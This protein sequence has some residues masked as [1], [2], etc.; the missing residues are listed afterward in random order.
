[1][2][3]RQNQGYLI[4]I[5][6]LVILSLMLALTAF[7]GITKALE[8]SDLNAQAEAKLKQKTVLAKAYEIHVQELKAMIGNM[9]ESVTEI[10]TN[11]DAMNTELGTLAVT[12]ELGRQAV[13]EVIKSATAAETEFKKDMAL[14]IPSAA[15]EANPQATYRGVFESLVVAL[16][17]KNDDNITLQNEIT[18]IK[19]EA[20]QQI[21]AMKAT[22]DETLAN[23][24]ATRT[25][26][27]TEKEGRAADVAR[28]QS[29]MDQVV[30]SNNQKNIEFDKKAVEFVEVRGKLDSDVT[31]LTKN[32]G[33]LKSQL[34]SFRAENFDVADGRIERVADN[35]GRVYINLGADDGLRNNR[36]FAVYSQGITSFDKNGSK[37]KIEVTRILGPHSAEAKVTFEDV[38]NPILAGDSILSAVWDKGHRVEIALG[39]FFDLDFDTFDDRDKLIQD[40]ESNGGKVVAWHDS[41]GR[42]HGEITP[43]TRYFVQGNS[44]P[45]GPDFNPN[46]ARGARELR[47]QAQKNGIQII[48][49]RKLHEWMGRHLEATSVPLDENMGRPFQIREASDKARE[50]AERTLVPS[51]GGQ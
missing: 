45:E 50:E 48:D 26:L 31:E 10:G 51:G 38:L 4:G 41:E 8:F 11:I 27:Q 7:L 28:L 24:A 23:L 12:D 49:I 37:A 33:M 3:A 17:R 32:N 13:G 30:Q 1:M 36:T 21:A 39:G 22:L 6:V 42:V 44:Q 15:G 5:I 34:D 46:L 25:D 16:K 40:I 29:A 2:A 20:V 18:R 14:L 47:T 35:L 43:S 9:G 19:Q